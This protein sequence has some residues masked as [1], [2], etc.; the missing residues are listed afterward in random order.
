MQKGHFPLPF[1][2]GCPVAVTWDTKL[3]FGLKKHVHGSKSWKDDTFG[4]K[5]A[6][7]LEKK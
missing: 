5:I 1:D 7:T 2:L 6:H 3:N 4:M